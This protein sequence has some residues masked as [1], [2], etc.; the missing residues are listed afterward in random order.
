MLQDFA[1]RTR[2]AVA[3]DADDGAALTDEALP[4][5]GGARLDGDTSRAGRAENAL[6]I[7]IVPLSEQ[8]P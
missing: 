2:C 1:A 6:A 4:A 8:L 7:G 3:I 5:Q